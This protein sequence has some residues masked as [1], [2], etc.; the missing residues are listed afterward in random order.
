MNSQEY[1]DITYRLKLLEDLQYYNPVKFVNYMNNRIDEIFP[2]KRLL[3]NISFNYADC[4][5]LLKDLREHLKP[6]IVT[7]K[8]GDITNECVDVIV[9]AANNELKGGS[10]VDGAI[11]NAAGWNKLDEACRKIG[12]CETG[13]AVVTSA[14][15]MKNVKYIIHTVGPFCSA[16]SRYTGTPSELEM[17]QLYNCYY[18][19]LCL[20]DK[21]E[22]NTISFPSI[23]TGI[24]G[25]PLEYAPRIFKKAI[26]DYEEKNRNLR[27][28]NMICFDTETKSFYDREFPVIPSP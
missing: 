4:I 12:Y 18:N 1:D 23:A 8:L 2:D 11:H 5:D 27:E 6:I 10:G 7:I 24:Y 25:F 20:A 28:I 14:F 17:S 3:N 19:S 21:L 13:K 9:N 26:S 15:D 16:H 22:C